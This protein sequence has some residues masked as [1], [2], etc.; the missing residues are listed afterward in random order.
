MDYLSLGIGAL[1]TAALVRWRVS[2]FH[3]LAHSSL[4]LLNTYLAPG[5]EDEKLPAIEQGTQSLLLHLLRVVGWLLFALA[6]GALPV[7]LWSYSPFF[8]PPLAPVEAW[9]ILAVSVGASLPFLLPSRGQAASGYSSL[10]QL[11]HR[12]ALDHSYLGL[13]LLRGEIKEMDRQEIR[14]R[15]DFLIITGLA[16]AGTTSF[17]NAVLPL[18]PL[19]SLNYANM[20]F[21]LSPRRW[22]RIYRPKE[23]STRERSHQDGVQIGLHSSEALEEY[24]FKAQ[25]QDRYIDPQGLQEYKLSSEEYQHYLDYQRVVRSSKELRYAAKNNNFLLRY[26]SLRDHNPHFR[27]VLLFRQPLY[28][29]VSLMEKHRHYRNLQRQDSFIL[30]YMDWLGHHEFGQHHKPF[31]FPTTPGWVERYLDQAQLDTLEYWLA[32]WIAV[33]QFALSLHHENNYFV[34]YE[35]FC[36]QPDVVLKDVLKGWHPTGDSSFPLPHSNERKVEHQVDPQLEQAAKDIYQ[37]LQ[38]KIRYPRA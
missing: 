14:R 38:A 23:H 33:Y 22:S 26:R 15:E 21:L 9:S 4:S 25:A 28:Q 12:L 19:A 16:R 3:R 32:L 17:L 11:L 2:W 7:F 31:R 8:Q 10:A 27:M 1:V 24:F 20:P 29:A 5:S 6:A 18:A 36:S 13:R 35:D 34:A 37:Q 30:E